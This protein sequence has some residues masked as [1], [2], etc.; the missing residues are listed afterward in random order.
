MSKVNI[1]SFF[2]LTVNGETH[3][4][5]DGEAAGN[6]LEEAGVKFDEDVT[7]EYLGGTTCLP[8]GGT[9]EMNLGGVAVVMT[10]VNAPT[11]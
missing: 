9:V 3:H 2:D 10:G 5:I 11:R 7:E 4:A 6:I 8:V 1:A